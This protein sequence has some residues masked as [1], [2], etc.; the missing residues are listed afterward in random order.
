[1]EKAILKAI[2]GGWD[3]NIDS[4]ISEYGSF[5]VKKGKGI[6]DLQLWQETC[7]DPKFWQSLGKAMC[8]KD[9]F[10]CSLC[11]SLAVNGCDETCAYFRGN[12]PQWKYEWHKLINHLSEG[13]DIESF[14]NNLIK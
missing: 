7:L 2:L 14:F 11:N 4:N 5:W 6:K 8:W 1:M 10:Y 13:K 12:E 3:I 9:N